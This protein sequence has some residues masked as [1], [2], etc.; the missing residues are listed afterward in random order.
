M[1]LLKKVI[2]VALI[3]TALSAA[4]VSPAA[5]APPAPALRCVDSVCQLEGEAE[6]LLR[7]LTEGANLALSQVPLEK[8]ADGG[9]QASLNVNKD[10]TLSLPIGDV[11]LSNANLEVEVDE[12]GAIRRLNGTA[13]M[14]FPTFGLLDDVRVVTPAQA[15]VGLD[16]GKN[17]PETEFELVPDRPYLYFEADTA[18]DVTGRTAGR[19]GEFG[20]SFVPGQR[21]SI[22]IDTEEAVAYLDGHVTLAGVDQIA[23]LGGLLE[24]TP[25]AEY[26]PNALPLRERTQ[27]GLTGKFSKD[28]TEGWIKLSGAYL[29]DGGVLPARLGIEAEPV[30]LLGELTISRDGVLVDGVLKS[31]LEPET[32]FNGGARV[33]TLIPFTKEAGAGYA[34]IDAS[35]DAPAIKLGVAAGASAGEEGYELRGRLTTPFSDSDLSG[36]VT[37]ELPDVAGAVGSAAEKASETV[38]PAVG[39][40]AGAVGAA[41]GKAVDAVAPVVGSAADAVGS[42]AGS[43]AGAVGSAAGSAAG[44]VGSAAGKAAETVGPAVGTAAG[45][46][47]AAAG[48]AVDAMGPVVGKAVGAVG[49]AAQ[50]GFDLLG[51][52]ARNAVNA[53]KARLPGATPTPTPAPQ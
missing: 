31:A 50:Q 39:E 26:V 12:N 25:V 46:V 2:P 22:I 28:I 19:A 43:A 1:K 52:F 42:A 14:P 6:G 9:S 45:A 10:F 48:K 15:N 16:L 49:G 18:M 13:D 5:A 7:L 36:K 29:L 32:I 40:A 23:V 27:F 34:G 24:S 30:N 21:A 33:V 47:G 20:L 41:A 44:A 4:V 17:L 8:T 51:T 37:G 11:T 53:G 3:V 38:G 35:V